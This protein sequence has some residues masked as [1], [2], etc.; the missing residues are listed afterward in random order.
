M[1]SPNKKDFLDQIIESGDPEM[2]ALAKEIR[3]E[4]A[5]GIKRHPPRRYLD[6][7]DW[8]DAWLFTVAKVHGIPDDFEMVMDGRVVRVVWIGRR[9]DDD[10]ITPLERVAEKLG[11]DAD[12]KELR[13]ID[14][15]VTAPG[16]A[17]LKL[18]APHVDVLTYT[19]QDLKQNPRLGYGDP[20]KAEAM[21][22]DDWIGFS[23]PR[24]LAS[25]G[26]PP[27]PKFVNLAIDNFPELT[28]R[29]EDFGWSGFYPD[30]L[31][32]FG[33]RIGLEIHTQAP[34]SEPKEP[35]PMSE[36]QAALV[37]KITNAMPALLSTL[38]AEFVKYDQNV[39]PDFHEFL[40]HPH[41]WL[42]HEQDDGVSWTFVVGRTDN[43][44]FG[45]HAEFRGTEL[46][47]LWGGD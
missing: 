45:Y 23:Q 32:F 19:A 42:A 44:D 9:F 17:R 15:R 4:Y 22:P 21:Y 6:S 39:D 47:D 26:E 24:P 36:T 33:Q 7:K 29:S 8:R 11:P 12:L 14:T 46:T 28:L 34:T 5:E 20:K 16:I 10:S 38:Q 2:A 3:R 1:T 31:R 43:V 30:S 25:A 35:K 18:I 13:L 40:A 27:K 37:R 41:V